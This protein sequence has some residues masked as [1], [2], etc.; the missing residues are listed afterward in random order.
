MRYFIAL[1]AALLT[2]QLQAKEPRNIIIMIGDGMGPAYTT[3]YRYFADDPTTP[4][5]ES[6]V[7]DQM[8]TGMA[9]TYPDEPDTV[10]TDSAAAAT[11]LATGHKTYNG[12]IAVDRQKVALSSIMDVAKRLGKSTGIA[13]TSQINHAT[14]AAFLVHN[15]NR[16]NY[17]AIADAYFDDRIDGKFR[18]DVMFGGGTQY[19]K[20]PDRD[21][22]AEFEA[23]GYHF[24]S[25]SASLAAL[26]QGPALGLFADVG[27]PSAIDDTQGPRLDAMT[28]KAVELLNQNPKGFVLMVEGSQIDWAGHSNDIV[29]AMHEMK[30]FAKAIRWAK[31]FADSRDDT[32]VVVTADHSTGGLTLGAAGKYQWRADF[33]RKI[34]NSPGV[35]AARLAQE[36][37][38]AKAL[39][40]LLGFNPSKDET[41][42]LM[43]AM[44]DGQEALVSAIKSLIDK[45]SL[46][47]W[48][49]SGHT[50][51]DVPIFADGVDKDRFDGFMDNTEI[52]KRLFAL[53]Q[54]GEQLIGQFQTPPAPK[55]EATKAPVVA[56]P[57]PAAP[58]AMPLPSTPKAQS[59]APK[60]DLPAAKPQAAP[61]PAPAPAP[62]DTPVKYETAQP[63]APVSAAEAT[64]TEAPKAASEQLVEDKQQQ[65]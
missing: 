7:F 50:A 48:T 32:L 19:F 10:V 45:R 65:L 15:E 12:A 64:P 57:A 18:A 9:S 53:L 13:V 26:S 47:G 28:A 20:R 44:S 46:T 11:A 54:P 61:A 59:P 22:V 63:A 56:T 37:E 51:V 43:D 31:D 60:A 5:V 36:S 41:S 42:N 33:L 27:L 58:T 16:S 24:A 2:T 62:K 55:A 49:T 25:D 52:A 35:I 1:L 14:P 34:P 4:K 21:L 23:A 30:D 40:A 6:T 39:P 38:P 3:G 17:N 29:T 8:L